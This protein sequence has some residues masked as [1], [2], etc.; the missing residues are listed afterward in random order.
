VQNAIAVATN[1]A[2]TLRKILARMFIFTPTE[3]AHDRHTQGLLS[4]G[5]VGGRTAFIVHTVPIA[6]TSAAHA[7]APKDIGPKAFIKTIPCPFGNFR[8][9][10]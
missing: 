4:G 7:H 5:S 6:I 9:R 8:E 3:A 10:Y 2:M 1:V